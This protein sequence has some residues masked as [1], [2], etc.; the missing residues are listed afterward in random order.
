MEQASLQP[1]SESSTNLR[2]REFDDAL[3]AVA[4]HVRWLSMPFSAS[5]RFHAGSPPR[6][7]L[8]NTEWT[9]TSS[10]HLHLTPRRFTHVRLSWLPFASFP[11]TFLLE[12]PFSSQL[13]TSRLQCRSSA[14]NGYVSRN[15]PP[16][17]FRSAPKRHAPINT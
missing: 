15:A 3:T 1:W 4:H 13:A 16:S 6:T 2:D 10:R 9:C 14:M 8:R 5:R 7:E 11:L 12:R 17:P